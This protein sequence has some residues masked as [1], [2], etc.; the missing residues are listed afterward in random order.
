LVVVPSLLLCA[1]VAMGIASPSISNLTLLAVGLGFVLLAA[2][3][4]QY[5]L[6]I[7]VDK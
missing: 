4:L 3:A 1:F 2:I 5:F 7:K 6:K